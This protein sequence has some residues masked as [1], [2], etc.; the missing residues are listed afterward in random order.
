[1][2]DPIIQSEANYDRENVHRDR[3]VE[4]QVEEF[5]S[6][7]EEIAYLL[8]G[9]KLERFEHL[10]RL[11]FQLVEAKHRSDVQLTSREA[12]LVMAVERFALSVAE[13]SFN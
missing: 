12:G 3:Q 5:L 4:A 10:G 11:L 7:P 13:E 8:T 9:E 1:M 2:T 6:S